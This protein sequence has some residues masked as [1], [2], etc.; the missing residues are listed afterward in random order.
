MKISKRIGAIIL[1]LALLVTSV[2]T[3]GIMAS[4]EELPEFDTVHDFENNLWNGPWGSWF[5][6]YNYD[7]NES[8][9]LISTAGMDGYIVY[10]V[11]ENTPLY[12]QFKQFNG[13][14]PAF[15]ASADDM[16]W[17]KLDM[18]TTVDAEDGNRRNHFIAGIGAGN[19][20]IKI[21]FATAT[22]A[23]WQSELKK[24]CFNK[25]V[26][27][28]PEL[29]HTVDYE[30][31]LWGGAWGDWYQA[32]NVSSFYENNAVVTDSGMDGYLVYKVQVNTPIYAKFRRWDGY[33][34]VFFSSVDG[35]N[36]TELEVEIAAQDGNDFWYYRDSIGVNSRYLKVVLSAKENSSWQSQFKSISFNKNTEEWITDFDTSLNFQGEWDRNNNAVPKAAETSG[37]GYY[38][39]TQIT[40]GGTDSYVVYRTADNSPFYVRFLRREPHSGGAHPTFYVSPN[41]TDWTHVGVDVITDGEEGFYYRECMGAN[42]RYLKVVFS[43]KAETAAWAYGLREIKINEFSSDSLDF[44]NNYGNSVNKAFET[45]KVFQYDHGLL[46]QEAPNS[47][48][49]YK[50]AENSPFMTSFKWQ[51]SSAAP[52][53]YV[54][55]DGFEWTEYAVKGYTVG[56]SKL[57][58]SDG[59]GEGN[60]YIKIVI[61]N[62]T[63]ASWKYDLL[64]LSFIANTD[65]KA[66]MNT[67][68]NFAGE[69]DLNTYSL[70]KAVDYSGLSYFAD[71]Q[72]TTGGKD[73]Y[74]VY[75][76]YKNSAIYVK[77][78]R[79]E[80]HI[81]NAHPA[82][83]VSPNGTDWTQIAVEIET[84]GESGYYYRES[85]GKD[86]KYIKVVLNNNP[87]TGA[88]AY[89]LKTISFNTIDITGDGKVN[90]EDIVSIRKVLTNQAEL[91]FDFNGDGESDIKDLVFLKKY[92]A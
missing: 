27:G 16:T 50:V 47:Y 82:F 39:D 85:I 26:D 56:Q 44:V 22:G 38:G 37:I 91:S 70:P 84:D 12:A 21:V 1:A 18:Q 25:R 55:K 43:N 87:Q 41:G 63:D 40:T 49:V 77:F 89:G 46:P 69:W 54:S 2:L 52:S 62:G 24:V 92:L 31:N 23:H 72:I 61:T 51:D 48:I 20:Y 57:C 86:N 29:D 13:F 71:T 53:F 66:E 67:S 74:I 88:W 28:I 32:N 68:L 90:A 81:D 4:A 10:K 75:E 11:A 8:K 15:Y 35:I 80:P 58:Y 64:K 5:E 34:P 19:K 79:R 45:Y 3:G 36:W 9:G 76:T 59:I 73:S 60:K 42:N 14:E 33:T 17:N 6:G 78:M 7:H 65:A 83:F 30:N